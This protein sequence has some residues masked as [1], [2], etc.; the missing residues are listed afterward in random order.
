MMMFSSANED[1]DQNGLVASPGKG[2]GTLGAD[3]RLFHAALVGAHV[4]THAVF[5]L[6]ALLA[7]G[8]GERLLVRV[9]Q[10]VAVEVVNIPE[11][12]AA[13]LTGV[14]LPHGV[15]VGVGGPLR[16]NKRRIH[17]L[18]S[19]DWTCRLCSASDHANARKQS[20]IQTSLQM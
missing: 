12:F 5:P 16:Q 8:T 13:R 3:V 4:V 10:A 9:G 2:L 1:S 14:V 6:E 19:L 20:P 17:T 11:G 15:G 7:D 18:E